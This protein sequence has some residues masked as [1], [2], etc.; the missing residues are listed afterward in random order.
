MAFDCAFF[1]KMGFWVR[2]WLDERF[3]R[4]K[5]DSTRFFSLVAMDWFWGGSEVFSWT[6]SVWIMF[7][8]S[9]IMIVWEVDVD[10]LWHMRITMYDISK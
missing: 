5:D 3:F 10:E 6:S 9:S 4:D 7:S 8:G 1:F 2:K